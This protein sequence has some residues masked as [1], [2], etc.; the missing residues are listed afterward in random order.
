MRWK[1]RIDGKEPFILWRWGPVTVFLRECHLHYEGGERGGGGKKRRR[2]G[3]GKF[4]AIKWE[5]LGSQRT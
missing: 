2:G 3:K 1:S 5:A 4:T